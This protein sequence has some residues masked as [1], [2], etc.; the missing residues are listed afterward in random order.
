VEELLSSGALSQGDLVEAVRMQQFE[1]S[2]L[3]KENNFIK[4]KLAMALAQGF[5]V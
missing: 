2:Q 5:K 1:I 4:S 3:R